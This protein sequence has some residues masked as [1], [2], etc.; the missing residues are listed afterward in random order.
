MRINSCRTEL[1]KEK[2]RGDD[3]KKEAKGQQIAAEVKLACELKRLIEDA[4][5]RRQEGDRP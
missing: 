1:D 4:D 3:A 2:S 5:R